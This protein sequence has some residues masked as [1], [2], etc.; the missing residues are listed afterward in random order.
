MQL[1]GLAFGA[2]ALPVPELVCRADGL[3]ERSWRVA[4][5]SSRASPPD[6]LAAELR[7]RAL[8]EYARSLSQHGHPDDDV[9]LEVQAEVTGPGT[10]TIVIARGGTAPSW[11]MGADTWV[12]YALETLAGTITSLQ[13][14]NG[15]LWDCWP[16]PARGGSGGA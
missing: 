3:R 4:T 8:R 11:E 13:E 7:V 1:N 12:L 16:L 14:E 5:S 9:A 15:V 6:G 2:M 10:Y